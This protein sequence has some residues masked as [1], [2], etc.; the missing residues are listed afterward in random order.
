MIIYA[1]YTLCFSTCERVHHIEEL[2]RG[3]LDE[4][5][6]TDM[7]STMEN[8]QTKLV[9]II[10]NK[11]RINTT[12]DKTSIEMMASCKCLRYKLD[13]LID[14]LENNTNLVVD[15]MLMDLTKQIDKDI[16]ISESMHDQIKEL[17]DDINTTGNS[18]YFSTFRSLHRCCKIQKNTELY[19]QTI[20]NEDIN[21]TF[22]PN[23]D[24]ETLL[25]ILDRLGEVTS[26]NVKHFTEPLTQVMKPQPDQTKLKIQGESVYIAGPTKTYDIRNKATYIRAE[27]NE[28]C[29]L[30]NGNI[31]ITGIGNREKLLSD[32]FDMKDEYVLPFTSDTC[33]IVDNTVAILVRRNINGTVT[34]DIQFIDTTFDKIICTKTTQL[35]F[36]CT[37]FA[38]HGGKLYVASDKGLSTY[39]LTGNLMK[40]L[41]GEDEASGV[42]I[43]DNGSRIYVTDYS[44]I[45]TLDDSG[46]KLLTIQDPYLICPSCV[47]V[48]DIGNV[49]VLGENT[50][51]QTDKDGKEKLTTLASNREG[52]KRPSCMCLNRKT[53]TLLIGQANEILAIILE[54]VLTKKEL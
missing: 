45:I 49:L 39:S 9:Q 32:T 41:Y 8:L 17:L 30:P 44:T 36:E 53:N 52:V 38:Y 48:T 20:D 18:N 7:L 33:Y 37:S 50:V 22:S 28:I 3:L 46:R 27:V 6:F 47:V 19:L 2:A 26:N 13:T 23:P 31:I 24:I 51:I 5:T 10:E 25:S 29:V 4:K 14:A 12:L 35:G 34:S 15:S 11:K 43:S 42:G 40:K 1:L 21:L 54:S 16:E